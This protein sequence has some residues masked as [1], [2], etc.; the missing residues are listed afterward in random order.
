MSMHTKTLWDYDTEHRRIYSAFI[1]TDTNTLA[2]ESWSRLNAIGYEDT[3][4]DNG[5]TQR[6][7]YDL[8]ANKCRELSSRAGVIQN[9]YW[10]S[11]DRSN[12]LVISQGV[13]DSVHNKIIL[14]SKQGTQYAYV[15]GLRVSETAFDGSQKLISYTSGNQ[16]ASTRDSIGRFNNYQYD[17]SY[18]LIQLKTNSKTTINTFN[19][20]SNLVTQ[21]EPNHSTTEFKYNTCSR[22]LEQDTILSSAGNPRYRLYYDYV[23]FESGA[24]VS[25]VRGWTGDDYGVRQMNSAISYT[26]NGI[27]H[28]KLGT[29][30]SQN[31]DFNS[32]YIIFTA[33]PLGLIRQKRHVH[34]HI[35][36]LFSRDELDVT[37][38]NYFYSVNR[39]YMGCYAAASSSP[40]TIGQHLSSVGAHGHSHVLPAAIEQMNT[41]AKSS[42]Q[43]QQSL[44][45]RDHHSRPFEPIWHR[46][47]PSRFEKYRLRFLRNKPE[48]IT[49]LDNQRFHSF[50]QGIKYHLPAATESVIVTTSGDTYTAI[51]QRATG[52]ASNA[53]Q[54]AIANHGSVND[55]NKAL[56]SGLRIRVPNLVPSRNNAHT[57]TPASILMSQM[58]GA[59]T[60]HLVFAQKHRKHHWWSFIVRVVITVVTGIITVATAGTASPLLMA[61][62]SAV[63]DATLQGISYGLGLIDNFSLSEVISSGIT[64]GMNK[65]LNMKELAQSAATLDIEAMLELASAVA[66]ENLTVQLAEISLGLRKHIDLKS[67]ISS[68]TTSV[69]NTIAENELPASRHDATR[70][71]I[72]DLELHVIESELDSMISSAIMGED[73]DFM[74]SL[75]HGFERFIFDKA[76]AKI[77]S[78]L[79]SSSD[80]HV[81]N[82]QGLHRPAGQLPRNYAHAQLAANG[83]VPEHSN[84]ERSQHDPDLDSA[85]A[86]SDVSYV[87]S[88]THA[89]I[90]TKDMAQRQESSL[91]NRSEQAS[92]VPTLPS[93]DTDFFF[94]PAY[95]ELDVSSLYS[96]IQQDV[97]IV[98]QPDA[99][100]PA[101][102]SDHT[103]TFSDPHCTMVLPSTP[104][105]AIKPPPVH[106]GRFYRFGQGIGDAFVGA[107]V[108]IVHP[109]V[110]VYDGL[111]EIPHLAHDIHVLRQDKHLM[112]DIRAQ[113]HFKTMHEISL[114]AQGVWDGTVANYNLLKQGDARAWGRL[115]GNAALSFSPVPTSL[116]EVITVGREVS[117]EGGVSIVA[118]SA[119]RKIP[120]RPLLV[121]SYRFKNS[122]HGAVAQSYKPSLA[123]GPKVTSS[124]VGAYSMRPMHVSYKGAIRS[125]ITTSGAGAYSMHPI[126]S[127]HPPRVSYK[128]ATIYTAHSIKVATV[129]AK[130]I[131]TDKI[132]HRAVKATFATKDIAEA[133]TDAGAS[134]LSVRDR[135]LLSELSVFTTR[136]IKEVE[137]LSSRVNHN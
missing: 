82:H 124:R 41:L 132:V 62:V 38:S 102:I 29:E 57:E 100:H 49:K 116:T 5:L 104:T 61:V 10:N 75:E 109:L 1:H 43:R 79:H 68:I 99:T 60:P 86:E 69:I 55:L 39:H 15:N 96:P 103:S 31:D 14:S 26:P 23:Y 98:W 52:D 59:L 42:M 25:G 13:Y 117:V 119:V 130:R 76:S 94:V 46:R 65:V 71:L 85:V 131:N 101:V 37:D 48:P 22:T 74:T 133:L 123:W 97:Y 36:G 19:A 12:R 35:R 63:T 129:K 2:H 73:I 8:N 134:P 81:R 114:D 9:D 30:D 24:H 110:V 105:P 17:A 44:I 90:M 21:V 77:Q 56:P 28:T 32:N 89:A 112:R 40:L 16:I 95:G 83:M 51:A 50:I 47:Y 87:E 4:L 118:A 7:V 125:K 128:G 67:I 64:A 115:F 88:D 3:V 33:D 111:K 70:A 121:K 66:I 54:I 127:M 122:F 72:R 137:E 136:M 58:I 91:F 92:Q 135:Q 45:Y 6:F 80:H 108:G 18:R 126:H 53:L 84:G 11:F 106:H 34:T 120:K 20:D 113:Y 107:A 78:S 27:I 93:Q